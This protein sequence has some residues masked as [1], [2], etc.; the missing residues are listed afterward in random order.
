[1]TTPAPIS[2]DALADSGDSKS[3]AP[4]RISWLGIFATLY[5]LAIRQH[6]HGKRWI[7]A[8]VLF[9]L[10]AALALIIR[11]TGSETPGRLLEFV[12]LWILIPQALLPLVALLYASGIIQDE[13]EEQT[14]TYLLVRPISKAT[15]YVVKMIAMWTTSALLV[16]GLSLLTFLAIYAGSG[17]GLASVSLRFLETCAILSLAVIA[18]CSLFGLMSLLTKRVLVLGVVYTV[19]VE[20]LLASLPL[21]VR[22]I[23]II[24]YTRLIAYRT[25]DFVITWPRGNEEDVAAAAWYLDTTADPGLAEHAGLGMC[26]FVLLGFA[27]V[28]T[29]IG[30]WVCAQREFRVKTPDR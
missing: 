22:M 2:S 23:T 7:V 8:A 13:L 28:C 15:V 12:L 10:P 29:A 6:L 27:V 30:A 26:V 24:Y 17:A 11:A 1:M 14:I 21:S 16:V 20:G 25:L 9:L 3:C 18:Y 4:S 19:I 5:H